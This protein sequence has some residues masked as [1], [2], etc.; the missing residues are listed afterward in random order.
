MKAQELWNEFCKEKKIDP[1]TPYEAWAFGGDDPDGLA[2]LVMRGI[3]TATAS[4]YDLYELDGE[5]EEMPKEGDYSVILDHAEEACCVIRTS[6]TRVI[7]FDEVDEEQVYKEGEG[8]RSLA[9]WRKFRM[10]STSIALQNNM[11]IK[12]IH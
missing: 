10:P 1:A 7:P 5:E 12:N 3:K 9:Y 8:D 2:S 11:P 6:R 4:G